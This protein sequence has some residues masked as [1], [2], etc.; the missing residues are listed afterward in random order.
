VK[1]PNL[2]LLVVGILILTQAHSGQCVSDTSRIS[3]LELDTLAQTISLDL[4]EADIADVL[5]IFSTGANL[6]LVS[7][8]EVQGKITGRLTSVRI[9][10]ALR[11]L[12]RSCGYGFVKEGEIYRI[13]KADPDLL[14]VDKNTPQ[15]QIE[16]KIVEA[17]LDKTTE[18]GINWERL[19]LVESD[20]ITIEGQTNLPLGNSGLFLNI[21][22]ADADVVVQCLAKQVRTHILSNP[23][24]VAL[25]NKEAKILVGDKVAY[26]QS[27]GQTA[28]GITTTSVLFE[29]VGIKLFVTPHVTDFNFVIL[30]IHAEVSTVKEW[31]TLSN[32]DEVPI[33]GTKETETVVT[34]K[35]NSTLVIGG[36]IS[37]EERVSIYKIPLLGDIPLLKFLFQYKNLQKFKKELVVFISPKLIPT[38]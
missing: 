38:E 31:R 26:Q 36:L 13:V 34:V 11:S 17:L 7:S 35:D 4:K 20:D 19:K 37:E 27:F 18:Q 15:I 8:H 23:R 32:G 10:D 29:D 30:K 6:N 16:S 12:L 25:D 2:I 21:F 9:E 28:S 3:G 24:I 22:H 14:G 33:I 5:R 1:K